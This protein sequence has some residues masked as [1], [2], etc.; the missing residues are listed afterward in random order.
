ML[1]TGNQLKAAR[2]LVGLEQADLA[3]AAGISKN[4][5][6]NMEARGADQLTSGFQ[7]VMAVQRALE[8][9]GVVFLADGEQVDGGP[10][11]R[12]AKR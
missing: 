6:G 1:T 8:A 7:T 5:I 10:G 9:A 2:Y 4:T 12:L 11:V 3:K